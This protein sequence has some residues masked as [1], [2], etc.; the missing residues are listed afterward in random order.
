MTCHT[1]NSFLFFKVVV[2]FTFTLR[3]RQEHA[4]FEAL[5]QLVPSLTERLADG[6]EEEVSHI[7]NM[8][9][10]SSCSCSEI[11]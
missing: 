7:A 5:L 6:S 3:E 1:R 10:N 9:T 4:A 2:I 11:R 8:V